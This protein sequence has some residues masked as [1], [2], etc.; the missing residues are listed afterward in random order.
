[1]LPNYDL[2][3]TGIKMKKRTVDWAIGDFQS[4]GKTK[5]PRGPGASTQGESNPGQ[6]GLRDRNSPTCTL[7]QNGYGAGWISGFGLSKTAGLGRAA[8][9]KSNGDRLN[10]ISFF[11]PR[12][13]LSR[14]SVHGVA[15]STA[16][17][18]T[19]ALFCQ[20]SVSLGELFFNEQGF[21]LST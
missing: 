15:V 5:L 2:E 3:A 13:S 11:V 21:C 4:L 18:S 10:Q 20:A 16:N 17:V 8:A 6:K 1:M 7:S 9:A 12:A 19:G 14:G